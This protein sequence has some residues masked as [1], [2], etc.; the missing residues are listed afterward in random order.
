M[1]GEAALKIPQVPVYKMTTADLEAKSIS[2]EELHT[3][4]VNL[5]HKHYHSK[6]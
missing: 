6:V 5:I 1:M 4:L 2:L 3:N